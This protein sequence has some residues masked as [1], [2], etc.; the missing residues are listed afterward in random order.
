MKPLVP[1]TPRRP[2]EL[3]VGVVLLTSLFACSGYHRSGDHIV[4][5][6]WDEGNGHQ[7]ST[8][9]GADAASFQ[10][11][12][13][14]YAKDRSRAYY[15]AGLIAGAQSA[16][17]VALTETY[18]R[19]DTQVYYE[20]KP[21]P[22]ADPA[23]FSVMPNDLGFGR[24]SKNVYDGT[25]VIHACDPASFRLLE[26][27]WFSDAKCA[28]VNGVQLPG[29]DPASFVVLNFTYAKDAAHV[30][31]NLRPYVID[32]ADAAT[33][34]LFK[35]KILCDA[36]RISDA[37]DRSRYYRFGAVCNAVKR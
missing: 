12:N 24:D 10:D 9:D 7:T 1:R 17:F 30:Y 37:R 19:D 11:L 22:G 36:V 26:R 35:G 32:G 28:Y 18:A 14:V 5:S 16:S 34:E 20:G 15:K 33:F 25:V 6:S 3:V 23:S 29:A 31:T 2:L 21:V 13:G 8:L 27:P 4:Y